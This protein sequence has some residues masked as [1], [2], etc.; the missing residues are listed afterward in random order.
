MEK[1]IHKC[2]Q[3]KRGTAWAA[4]CCLVL[5]LLYGCGMGSETDAVSVLTDDA[6]AA[7][8]ELADEQEPVDAV[9]TYTVYVCG[10]V[11][12]P[13]VY[14]LS[15]G[16]RIYQALEL[17]GGLSDEAAAEAVNQAEVLTDGEMIQIPT[18]AE[19]EEQQVKAAEQ[20]D[21]LVNINTAS[22]EELKTLPGIGDAR[23]QSIISYRESHGAFASIQDIKN[24]DGIG[25]GTYAKLES[26][27]KVE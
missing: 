19:L 4:L 21:G 8:S 20:S 11:V 14:E 2:L 22:L 5:L 24:I 1:K 26:C 27:I 6:D 25:D 9:S 13:G 3:I 10:A 17:A 15:A 12:H 18:A 23:A 16:S 7:V